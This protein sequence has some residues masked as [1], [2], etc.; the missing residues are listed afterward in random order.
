MAKKIYLS[1]SNQNDNQYAAGDTNEMI[2][3]NKIA[4][5]AEKALKRCGFSVKKAPQGQSMYVSVKESNSWGADMHLPIHTNAFD[6]K[7]TGGTLVML[8][9]SDGENYRAGKVILNQVGPLTPGKDYAIRTNTGL[10][11]LS[12]TSAIAVYTEVEF[13]DTA[14]GALFII[15]NTKKIGEA[16]TKGVCDFYG[17]P[18]RAEDENSS[19]SAEDVTKDMYRVRKSW[20]DA[21]TQIGAFTILSNA[22]D[23]ADRNRG[24]YVFD[25]KGKKVYTPMKQ[26]QA[27][28]LKKVPLYISA[29]APEK[30]AV[31]DGTYYRW[32]NET[33]SGRVRITN[34]R[35]NVGKAGQVTGWVDVKYVV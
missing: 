19:G 20:E 22:K 3:C 27:I 6:G 15:N 35:E 25:S 13:H 1:P 21:K 34:S 10:Y 2:Q 32:D 12:S 26:A 18:Y 8:Y 7:T 4:A 14:Q 5:A 11:E 30:S 31:V 28:E 24:Y 29:D 16:I 33:V 17:I 9:H 23:M